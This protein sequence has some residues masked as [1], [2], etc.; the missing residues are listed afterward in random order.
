MVVSGPIWFEVTRA[1][2]V[3]RVRPTRPLIGAG[4]VVKR[5][6]ML[7]VSRAARA[8]PTLAAACRAEA[9]ALV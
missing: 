7:A 6:L 5:R 2:T 9:T 8:W 4:T 3:N 1:P